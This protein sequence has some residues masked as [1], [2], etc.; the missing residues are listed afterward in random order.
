M[1]PLVAGVSGRRASAQ[2]ASSYPDWT[3]QYMHYKSTK[4]YGASTLA[5][6]WIDK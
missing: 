3:Y 4:N 1:T 2:P 6:L 5:R